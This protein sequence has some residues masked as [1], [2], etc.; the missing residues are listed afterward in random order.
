[1]SGLRLADFHSHLVPGVD[2]GSRTLEDAMEGIGR[3]IEAGVDRIITT[4]HFQ[5]SATKDPVRLAAE[6]QRMDE[7]WAL[8]QEAVQE[9]WPDVDFRRG[10]EV[11]LDIPDPDLSDDRLHLGGT[12]SILVEWPRFQ[13]PPGTAQVLEEIVGAGLT[14]VVAH[15]ERYSGIDAQLHVVR[16]WK[17]TGALLQANYGSLVGR[18]GPGPRALVLRM[19]SEGLLDYLSTD[20]HG[21]P[22]LEPLIDEAREAMVDM[23]GEVVFELLAAVNPGR[24]FDGQPPLPVPPVVPE[25]TLLERIRSWISG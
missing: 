2:D 18:Y 22:H 20:F 11:L 3:M 19:L 5:G 21:R 9:E 25:P 15:P 14:P 24:L 10:H 1:V 6:L 23:G 17:A 7:G 12:T 4:P 13:V 8:V 16:H